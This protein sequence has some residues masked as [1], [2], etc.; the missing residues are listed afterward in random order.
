[1]EY[2]WKDS[3]EGR[4]EMLEERPIKILLFPSQTQHELGCASVRKKV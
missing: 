4:D 1:M 2:Q 3:D